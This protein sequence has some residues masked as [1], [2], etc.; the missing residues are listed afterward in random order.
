MIWNKEKDISLCSTEEEIEWLDNFMMTAPIISV[1]TETDGVHR[2][3]NVIGI[4][5]AFNED[6]AFYVPFKIYNNDTGLLEDFNFN[7]TGVVKKWLGRDD[8]KWILH[9]A[10]FDIIAINN[11][12]GV[13][14]R[15]QV[16]CDTMLLAHT[17]YNEEGPLALKSLAASLLDPEA[18]TPQLDV[19][20]NI[21]AKGGA[22]S[23]GNFE[24][25]KCD[26]P[27]LGKYACYDVLYTFGVYNRL[28]PEI[29]RQRLETLWSKEVMPLLLPMVELNESGIAIDKPYFEMLRTNIEDNIIKIEDTIYAEIEPHIQDYE[30]TKALEDIKITNR[31]AFGKLLVSQGL[32]KVNGQIENGLEF[33]VSKKHIDHVAKDFYKSRKQID[34]IFNLDSNDDK[35]FLLYDC[36]GLPCKKLT[37]SGK[38]STDAGTLEDLC[39]QFKD[40]SPIVKLLLDRAAESKLLSTYV[41]P[42]IENEVN[43]VLYASFNQTGTISGR[44]SSSGTINLQTLPRDDKRIKKGFVPGGGRLIIASDYSQLEPRCFSFVS[45]EEKLKDVFRKKGKDFYSQIAVDVFKLVGVSADESA[46][47]Y[48]KTVMPDKRHTSKQFSLAVPYGSGPGRVSQMLNISFEEAKKLI[49]SYLNTYPKLKSWMSKSEQDMIYKGYVTN[50]LGRKRRASLVHTLYRNYSIKSFDKRTIEHFMLQAGEYQGYSDSVDLYLACR[51]NLNNA[52]NFQIQG[53]GASICNAA[54]IDFYK[55]SKKLKLQARLVAQVHDE[56]IVT[57]PKETADQTAKLLQECME[58]N[59]VTRMLDVPMQAEPVIT[60]KSLAEAK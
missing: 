59:W 29:A 34:K 16:F 31:S 55:Q 35:A 19:K 33:I 56:I 42:I 38:R 60:A 23:K 40:K 9:N 3:R 20:E 10:V 11:S 44:L 17:V 45:G 26:W 12:F 48:L 28:Y 54:M 57:C 4:S 25:W 24:M 36:L 37:K 7:Q 53:L 18:L 30:V 51:N 50:L 43:G 49:D 8:V 5:F 46:E 2:F 21:K 41:L 1:D 39:E 47:N 58:N 6:Q 32:A 27:L 13:D 22:V 52:K 15:E 14:I